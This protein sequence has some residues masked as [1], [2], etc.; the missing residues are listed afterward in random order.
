MMHARARKTEGLLC[1]RPGQ[2][3][4]GA[5]DTAFVSVI[6]GVSPLRDPKSLTP[7]NYWYSVLRY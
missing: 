3:Q 7:Y 6:L 2:W 4:M 5:A 1:T